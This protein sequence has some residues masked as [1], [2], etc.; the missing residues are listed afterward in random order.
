MTEPRPLRVLAVDDHPVYL[1]GLV[2]TL[3]AADGLELCATAASAAEAVESVTREQS[4]VVLLDLN[5]PD[6]QGVDVTRS[7]KGSGFAGALLRLTMYEG[8]VALRAA[9]EAG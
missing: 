8:E 9:L 2:A 6:G 7:L 5:I 4:D 3:E 1:R